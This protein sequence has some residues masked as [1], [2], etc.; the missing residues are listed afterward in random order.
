MIVATLPDEQTAF[1]VNSF[2]WASGIVAGT[3]T[4]LPL[5]TPE[6]ADG[7]VTQFDWTPPGQS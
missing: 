6:E 7:A 4:W 2:G 1:A 5:L 3:T